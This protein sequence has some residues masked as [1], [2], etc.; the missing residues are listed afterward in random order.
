[1]DTI[2]VIVIVLFIVI[3][4]LY[5]IDPRIDVAY[6]AYKGYRVL[7][8]YNNYLENERKYIVLYTN[9]K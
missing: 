9:N 7:L 5:R 1:M 3:E 8:W 6:G 2:V 4:V